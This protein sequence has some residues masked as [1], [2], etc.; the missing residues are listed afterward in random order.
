MVT[1]VPWMT[2]GARYSVVFLFVLSLLLAGGDYF[3]GAT[4]AA[5]LRA[6]ARVL[7]AQVARLQA[8]VLASCDFAAD[9]G[10]APLPAAPKPGKLG[11]KLV[12]DSRAQWRKLDCPGSLPVPP[13]FAHWATVYHLP[14][15]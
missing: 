12:A 9:L 15:K 14:A 5:H 10:T 11:V 7:A 8:A 4:Q 13:G 6:Q 1:S 3:L 2:R